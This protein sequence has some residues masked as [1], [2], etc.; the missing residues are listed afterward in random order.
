MKITF[1]LLDINSEVRD[2]V[3][4]LWLW[5]ITENDERVLIID[6]N[7]VCYFYAVIKEGFEP[8]KVA[9]EISKAH[10]LSIV[11]LEAAPRRFFGKPVQTIKVYCR[12]P[13]EAARL[14]KAVRE[15]EGVE[16]CLEDDVR[17][18]MQYLVSNNV[19]PCSWHEVDA[20]EAENTI[21]VRADKIYTATSTPKLLN[22]HDLPA[23]RILSFS[24]ICYSREGSPKPDRNPIVILS[25]ATSSG[26]DKQFLAGEDKDDKPLLEQFLSY[27]KKF[28]PDIIAGYATNTVGWSYL[29]ERS[30]K[31]GIKL[32]IDRACAEPHTSVY[33]HTSLTGIANLDLA[34]FADEF[35]DIK[36]KT[37]QNLADYLGIM[38]TTQHPIIDDVDFADYWDSKQK[39]EALKTFAKENAL[40]IK[41]ATVALLDFAIQLSSLVGL[42]LDHVM[43]AA[44]GF[45]VEWFFIKHAQKIS[46]LVPKR[47]EQPYKPYAGGIVLKPKAGLHTNIAVLDFKSMYPNIMITY[48]LSPDTYIPPSEPAPPSGIFEAPEVK[49]K[50][51]RQPAGF[52]KE[53]LS[54][55]IDTR[56]EVR[57]KMKTLDPKSTEYQVLDARQ[58]AVK[59]I[60]N[61]AYGYAGWTGARW[62][63]KPVAEAASAWG[64]HTILAAI[65]MAEQKGLRVIYGDTDSLFVAYE[66]KQIQELEK[67]IKQELGLEIERDKLYTRIFFTEA[68]KRYAGLLPDGSIDIVGL[69]VIRGDWAEVAKKVQEQVL[70]IILKEQAPSKAAEYVRNVI[71]DLRQ[72]KVPFRDLI[73]WKTL[74]K[75]VEEYK[76]KASHVEAAKALSRKGWKMSVGDKVGYVVLTGEGRLYDR[77]KPYV[78]AAYGE[79]DTEY[80]V[81]K[82]VAPAA[83]RVLE[84][85]G[86]TEEDLLKAQ[87]KEGA[88]RS[89]MDFMRD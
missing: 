23:L 60:T 13:N 47:V 8:A 61:A 66:E 4:E 27:V 18:T 16:M 68:K 78:F 5:G 79:V 75:P 48:N 46:E 84:F 19:V 24:M 3:A 43:T 53:V 31:L 51:R 64:R 55:L 38:K 80:Y 26:E 35:P 40:R 42:P 12:S 72:R 89:L 32:C 7:F 71:A 82:Q 85:F 39:R 28:N 11:K 44:V 57:A 10:N 15:I 88:A 50:F 6:R 59:V 65:K 63:R 87:K 77:V 49:H 9:E 74:T 22:R 1:W 33:G 29:K 37:L 14:A 25:A 67:Q 81:T 21:G 56:N 17:F 54:Y 20:V 41:G 58:K 83:A 36:V 34:D 70:E 62:Y 69:E 76:I 30:S 45:R 73:I 52:Y 2:G 86:I